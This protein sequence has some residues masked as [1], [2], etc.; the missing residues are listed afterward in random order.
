MDKYQKFILE[1]AFK[2]NDDVRNRGKYHYQSN[3][4]VSEKTGRKDCGVFD[5]E[6]DTITIVQDDDI[7]STLYKHTIEDHYHESI[8][9]DTKRGRASWGEPHKTFVVTYLRGVSITTDGNTWQALP[10]SLARSEGEHYSQYELILDFNARITKVKF[11]FVNNLADDYIM[12]VIYVEANKEEFHRKKVAEQR[13]KLIEAA[14]IKCETKLNLVNIYFAPCNDFY[15]HTVIALYKDGRMLAKHEVEQDRYYIALNNLAYGDYTFVLSQ[16]AKDG[17]LIFETDHLS[18]R[19][20][21][22]H[23]GRPSM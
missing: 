3:G 18:F 22:P 6:H 16:Y 4:F 9:N 7:Y 17:S 15:C 14:N 5:F 20:I 1:Q 13:L 11:S 21:K 23:H 12:D 8:S 10:D 2:L 19:I